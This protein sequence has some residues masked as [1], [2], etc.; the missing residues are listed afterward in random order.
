MRIDRM[1]K[2]FTAALLCL[3][4]LL[5]GCGG[6]DDAFTTPPT[7]GTT[8]AALATLALLTSS[9]QLPSDGAL[10]V[11]L[12][13]QVKDANNNLVP[14]VAVSF[15]ADSGSLAVTQAITDTT[16]QAL[17]TLSTIGNPT[18]RIITVTA[19]VSDG[20]NTLTDTVEVNVIGTQLTI[21]GPNNLALGDVGNYSIKLVNAAGDAIAD[22]TVT[23]S[24]AAG[25]PLSVTSLVTDSAGAGQFTMTAS[26]NDDD[27]LSA[28]ALG[29]TTTRP[30]SVSSDSF[31]FVTPSAGT[32]I[33]L[34]TD[35]TVKVRWTQAGV[36]VAGQMVNFSTTRGVLTPTSGVT[37]ASGE[38][39]VS[40]RSANAGGAS[41]TA[42]TD[43]GPSTQRAVEFV[44]T[45]ADT[46]EVQADPF[47]IAPNEQATITAI[48]RDPNNNL[49]K[50]KVVVFQLDDV[51]GGS[52]AVG[53]AETDSQGRAQTVYTASSVTSASGGV[54]I[55]AFVQDAPAV[56]DMTALT[57]ARREVFLSFGTGNT[58]VEPND[59]QY[60]MPFVLFVTDSDGN[61]VAGAQVQLSI[62]STHYIKGV[63]FADT[64]SD[65][66]VADPSAT[67]A[68]EDAN[69]NGVL[70]ANE[71]F[72]SNNH[73]EA[74]NI[75]SITAAA[76]TDDNGTVLFDLVYPQQ[77]G[78]WL[79]VELAGKATVQGT[80][81]AESLTF[82]LP[83][84]D[85]DVN[86]LDTAPPGVSVAPDDTTGFPGGLT[87]PFGYNAECEVATAPLPLH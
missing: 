87:S 6:K 59:A 30:V 42:A 53:S 21:T 46:L 20:T 38:L 52:L 37:N 27:T 50:N 25:N 23:I 17:A 1:H 11:N 32:E 79:E 36:P 33:A 34:N 82:V 13:A 14:D 48:V 10:P 77:Y 54:V 26:Q 4:A 8:G 73:V 41:I 47:T 72:N 16:G 18:N 22:E 67:C 63:W 74:G 55:T 44:A 86:S 69:R 80:E 28:S 15:S 64:I 7:Q 60:S 81:F 49:V 51:T 3:V 85:S 39:T 61:G 5:T 84:A 71:D 66:W 19:S 78:A 40:I 75:A 57:V 65:H 9:P 12:T 83:V 43:T 58:I 45:V 24:S 70:D 68:D 31:S 56:T 76:T 62:H 35:T 2:P 29:L